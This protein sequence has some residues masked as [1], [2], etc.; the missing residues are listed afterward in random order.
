MHG[1]APAALSY[2]FKRGRAARAACLCACVCGGEITRQRGHSVV[3][4][5]SAVKN[6]TEKLFCRDL[7]GFAEVAAHRFSPPFD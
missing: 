6:T 1:A 7:K 5:D 3:E 4:E 2:L